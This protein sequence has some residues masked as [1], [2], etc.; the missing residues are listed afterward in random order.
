MFA[1]RGKAGG[2]IYKKDVFERLSVCN[3][4]FTKVKSHNRQIT[5]RRLRGAILYTLILYNSFWRGLISVDYSVGL[6]NAKNCI[7]R[8]GREV[9]TYV[10]FVL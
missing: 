4:N 5:T 7:S 9:D 3:T 8:M 1:L 10:F 6:G 2:L